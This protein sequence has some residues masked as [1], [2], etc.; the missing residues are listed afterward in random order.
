MNYLLST[1]RVALIGTS[2]RDRRIASK[3]RV[4]DT[5]HLESRGRRRSFWISQALLLVFVAMAATALLAVC[6][7]TFAHVVRE[8]MRISSFDLLRGLS[9][10]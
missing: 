5:V 10:I 2:D 6:G 4:F 9:S 3:D 8:V 1:A 7:F